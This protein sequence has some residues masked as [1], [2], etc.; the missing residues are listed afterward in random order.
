MA[1]AMPTAAAIKDLSNVASRFCCQ[2]E[3]YRVMAGL[4]PP[5]APFP[6]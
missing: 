3:D 4:V 2:A 1:I 5:P 6:R